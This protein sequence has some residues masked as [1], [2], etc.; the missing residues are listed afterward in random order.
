MPKFN[1]SNLCRQY[2]RKISHFLDNKYV[3]EFMQINDIEMPQLRQGRGK[4]TELDERLRPLLE[5]WLQS[6]YKKPI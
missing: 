2:K 5:W 1:A 6:G 3:Q 4:S